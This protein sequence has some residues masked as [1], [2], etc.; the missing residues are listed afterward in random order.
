MITQK[1]R[2]IYY[3]PNEWLRQGGQVFFFFLVKF[4]VYRTTRE[5]E[6]VKEKKIDTSFIQ[7]S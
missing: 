1:S 4:K 6:N 2:I 5:K 3:I 7:E